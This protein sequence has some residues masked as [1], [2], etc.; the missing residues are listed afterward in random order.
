MRDA[1]PD[2][3]CGRGLWRRHHGK[4]GSEQEDCPTHC[5]LANRHLHTRSLASG[6]FKCARPAADNGDNPRS[7]SHTMGKHRTL[8]G[9]AMIATLVVVP[10]LVVLRTRPR[11][12][13]QTREFRAL[14]GDYVI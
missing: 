13:T 11:D 1:H 14:V 6:V 12:Y 2:G 4:H 5:F 7:W 10:M 3:M 9:L 8:G